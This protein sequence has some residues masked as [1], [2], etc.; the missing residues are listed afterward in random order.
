M[1]GKTLTRKIDRLVVDVQLDA[2][3]L[4][5]APLG[6]VEIGHDLDAA[7]DGGGDVRRRRHHF[8]QHAVDAI[9]HLE[10]ILERLEVNVRCLVLDR[11]QQHQVDQLAHRVGIGGFLQAVQVDR[12][13]A[14]FQ[15]LERIV[16]AQLAEDFADA[17]GGGLVVL[18]R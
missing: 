3:V 15:V 16:L 4:R 18:V 10:F 7:A 6:D 11:L 17:F 8:V 13:A 12:F 5:H 1:V 9:T 14:A 2:A